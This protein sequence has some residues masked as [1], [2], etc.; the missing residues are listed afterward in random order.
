MNYKKITEGIINIMKE[1]NFFII[2]DGSDCLIFK[3]C[4]N[5]VDYEVCEEDFNSRVE[6]DDFIQEQDNIVLTNRNKA[7]NILKNRN[8]LKIEDDDVSYDNFEPEITI[9]F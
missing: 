6:Y 9:Y 4:G 2:A 8:N 7:I 5:D 1:F 3:Y